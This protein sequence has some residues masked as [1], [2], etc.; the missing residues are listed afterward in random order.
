MDL[1]GPLAGL[2][3]RFFGNRERRRATDTRIADKARQLRR[4][5]AASFE[6]WARD[7]QT[8]DELAKWAH[9][10][11]RGYAVTDPLGGGGAAPPCCIFTVFCG[12][13]AGLMLVRPLPYK[14]RVRLRNL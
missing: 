3:E 14:A 7:P 11:A 1:L 5:L 4:Q 2:L 12:Q 6:D 13:L 8:L 10:L 9:K